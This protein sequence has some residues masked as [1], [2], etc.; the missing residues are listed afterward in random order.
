M[1]VG[2]VIVLLV[3]DLNAI[4]LLISTTHK[5]ELRLIGMSLDQQVFVCHIQVLDTNFDLMMANSQLFI[6]HPLGTMNVYTTFHGNLA[7]SF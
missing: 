7:I 5:V 6:T 2:I 3:S 4:N 1:T